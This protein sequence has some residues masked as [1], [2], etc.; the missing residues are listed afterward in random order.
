MNALETPIYGLTGNMGCGKTTVAKFFGE[1]RGVVI[2][3]ADEVAKELLR[4]ERYAEK[5]RGL[6]G[7][8]IF[9][10]GKVDFRKIA[11]VIF[12][13]SEA[14]RK[15][16]RFI[17]PLTWQA[18]HDRMREYTEASFFLVESALIYEAGWEKYFDA[19]VVVICSSEE[20]R[21]RLQNGRDLS[22]DEMTKRLMRQLSTEEKTRRADFVIDT[23]CSL[24]EMRNK[25]KEL[26]YQLT[27]RN[28]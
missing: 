28:V 11:Q 2:F 12:S 8:K 9:T 27:R 17:H 23:T 10:D 6:L 15:L 24:D 3:S 14:L 25:V 13:D 22:D 21:R 7:P 1:F 26:N 16:E 20:Q 5:L 4:E 19:I 18:I